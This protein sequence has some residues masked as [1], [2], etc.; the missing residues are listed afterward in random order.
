MTIWK[1]GL[2]NLRNGVILGA[3]FGAAIVWGNKVYSFLILNIPSAWLKFGELS[4]P[5][6]LIGIGAIVGYIIDRH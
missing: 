6:Y 3:L 4:L 2:D 5:L 1:R